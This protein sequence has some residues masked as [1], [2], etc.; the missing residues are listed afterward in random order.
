[1][2][3][4][5]QAD[6]AHLAGVSRATVSYV[7]SGHDSGNISTTEETRKR[8]LQAART[9]G[10]MPDAAAQ[11]LR[12][13]AT[14]NIG[15]LIP[16][17]H[18]PHYWQMVDG[19]EGEARAAGY[20]LL[21]T[22]AS[23]NPDRELDCMRA[24]LRGRV[25]GLV[26][27]LTFPEL[28]DEEARLLARRRCPVV[29]PGGGDERLRDLDC[30]EPDYA[31]GAVHMMERLLALG[32]RRIGLV[33][34][35]AQPE[36]GSERL[37]AYRDVLAA[38]GL[39]YD[40]DLVDRCG[41]TIADGYAAAGRLLERS[42]R[43]SAL[44]VINDLLAMGVLHAIAERG[45]RVPDDVSVAGFDDIDMAAYLNP[46]LTT[47]R[48]NAE[49]MGRAA[50]RLVFQRMRD[51]ERSPQRVRIPAQ[52]IERA[53]TGPAPSLPGAGPLPT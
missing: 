28:L 49:E 1:M 44:V 22:S 23:L 32:H 38:A 46:A 15:V 34:G 25:D 9:L 52:L 48:V 3:R 24:L 43:P 33:H 40:G 11:S 30:V 31:D 18:N 21:L 51:P 12:L 41:S 35:V 50:M 17:L 14:K 45:L 26:L 4:P 19:V 10:Y 42:P 2:K 13:G 39:P 16:D 5:T 27:S 20:D 6:V 53:S 7:I 37:R 47:L 36:L 8:V 29:V